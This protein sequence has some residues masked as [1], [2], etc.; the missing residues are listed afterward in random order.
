MNHPNSGFEADR[1]TP[2]DLGSPISALWVDFPFL[3]FVPF[4]RWNGLYFGS[5]HL[6]SFSEVL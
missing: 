5:F 2:Y 1:T 4:D 6:P 3:S